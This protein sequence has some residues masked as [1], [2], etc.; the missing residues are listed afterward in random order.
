MTGLSW[1]ERRTS[2]AEDELRTILQLSNP[3]ERLKMLLTHAMNVRE[4]WHPER[5]PQPCVDLRFLSGL[6][7]RR[8]PRGC[9]FEPL[10]GPS[11]AALQLVT[12]VSLH[13]ASVLGI[14]VRRGE[15]YLLVTYMGTRCDHS[16]SE[17]VLQPLCTLLE[18]RGADYVTMLLV[19][20]ADNL[21]HGA[22]DVTVDDVVAAGGACVQFPPPCGYAVMTQ[23]FVQLPRVLCNEASAETLTYGD[24]RMAEVLGGVGA[25]AAMRAERAV[26]GTV[27]WATQPAVEGSFDLERYREL[28]EGECFFELLTMREVRRG[29][30]VRPLPHPC[31]VTRLA[32]PPAPH[33][34]R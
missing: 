13:V 22:P 26:A 28:V 18:Y 15:V 31:D 16:A 32:P 25:K 24:E 12:Q 7:E 29:D 30:G 5:A 6:P 14:L 34:P 11:A 17:V 23:A 4:R 3:S 20:L 2:A 8:T 33:A 19:V 21:K 10:G 27:R 1:K 9:F